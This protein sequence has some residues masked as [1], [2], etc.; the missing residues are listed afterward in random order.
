M[1]QQFTALRQRYYRIECAW[2][3]GHIRWKPKAPE[4]PGETSHGVCP[5][6]YAT[7]LQR[8]HASQLPALV[9]CLPLYDVWEVLTLG[10]G[11]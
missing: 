6:C 8:L 10:V 2:C 3:H 1:R 9:L 4:L 11:L 7:L 5:A